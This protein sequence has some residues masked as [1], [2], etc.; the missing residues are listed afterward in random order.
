MLFP[1]L[2]VSIS[3]LYS[4]CP[5]SIEKTTWDGYRAQQLI[6]V[7]P[8]PEDYIKEC[9]IPSESLY[10]LDF[11]MSL[12]ACWAFRRDGE[13]VCP[14]NLQ[15]M[16][17][18]A[19]GLFAVSMFLG[20]V[21]LHRGRIRRTILFILSTTSA[22]LTFQF[23][24]CIRPIELGGLAGLFILL[25]TIHMI[26][27]LFLDGH[28]PPEEA[29]HLDTRLIRILFDYRGYARGLRNVRR[30]QREQPEVLTWLCQRFVAII[31][32]VSTFAL[33]ILVIQEALDTKQADFAPPKRTILRRI[34]E[35]TSH[36]I[37]IRI[38][39]VFDV[40][41]SNWVILA[42]VQH[43]LASIRVLLECDEPDYFIAFHGK[44][45]QTYTIRRFWTFF[46]HKLTERDF[47]ALG[48]LI[49]HRIAGLQP[50][51]VAA[52][53]CEEFNTF[54]ISGVVH[55]MITVQLG[56]RCGYM[57]D[58]VFFCL[59]YAAMLAEELVQRTFSPHVGRW[60]NGPV[61][62]A[63]GF[64][65]VYGFFFWSVPKQQYPKIYC[66]I[67]GSRGNSGYSET[68]RA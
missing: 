12:I 60:Q 36:E 25:W 19:P 18:H 44:V 33:Y 23:V 57:E 62:R 13:P 29:R 61:G 20:I 4:T 51:T 47:A 8:I 45:T 16:T 34:P 9:E 27:L 48:R 2:T 37:M 28:I 50:G 6:F 30:R 39:T 63:V 26:N 7:W 21:A 65:W 56:F 40:F 3:K 68:Y 66:G 32:I 15:A 46:W 55:A 49:S 24:R 43:A 38:W 5:W 59:N 67:A 1:G 31:C 10:V 41:Y 64:L 58:I 11:A 52:R 35:A 54:L 14:S 42:V 53:R 22:L 17:E